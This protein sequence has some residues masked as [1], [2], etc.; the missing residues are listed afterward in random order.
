MDV[1]LFLELQ[2]SWSEDSPHCLV[3]LHEMFWHAA[4]EGQKEVEQTIH[5]GCQLHTP[6]LNPEVGIP[7]IQLVGP[8]M[9]KEELME[10]YLEVYK[11]Y[12]CLVPLP[13]SQPFGRK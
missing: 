5:Q 7:T 3:F 12:G 9:T 6:Q 10:I 1:E 4:I 2:N 11:L 13:V 8:E